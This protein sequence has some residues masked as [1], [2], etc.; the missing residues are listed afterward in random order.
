M[1]NSI[2][3]STLMAALC[4][5]AI[6]FS[7]FGHFQNGLFYY[8]FT[9]KISLETVTGQYVLRYINADKAKEKI[10]LLEK[11]GAFKNKE[12]KDDRT[13]IINALKD[14]DGAALQQL[15]NE[16]DIISAQPL[17]QTAKEKLA[18]SATEEILVRFKKDID[19]SNI[20]AILKK[21]N[22]TIL[23]KGE[24]FYTV[25]VPRK[26][27]TLQ[28]A[29]AIME[30]G[31]AEFSHPNFYRDIIMHQVPNDEYFGQQWNLHNVGQLINDGHTGTAD[32]DID[33]PEAWARTKG[34]N[35]I[36]I[37]V[38]DE[39][40]TSNHFDLPNTRQVRL[41]GSNFSTATPGN[42]PSPVG[43]GNHGN[44][45]AG[46]VAAT[47]DNSQGVA[48]VA[49]LCK[50]MPIKIL[51][52]SASDANIANAITFAKN[53][54][55]Q[56]LSNSWGYGTSL[57][58]FVPAI[59][60]AIT[61]ATTTGR[62]GL[63]CV[64]VFAA[65]NT[66]NHA[67]GNN[68]F[69]TFPGNVNVAGVLT[70]GASDRYDAQ[71]NYSPTS[72]T[73]STDNQVVDIVAPSHRAYPSQIRGED[74]EIWSMDIPGATGYNPNTT[75]T[76]LPAAG[77]NFD[78]YTGRMGGTSAACPQ[79]AGAAALLLSLNA[80][81]TQQQVFNIL[82]ENAD[83]VGGYTYNASGFSNEMGYGRLNLYR[84]V[85]KSGPDLYMKDQVTDAGLEP[86]PD[87][88]SAYF[89]SPDIW[90]RNT[91]DGG[92]THQ[93][94][95]YGQTN[96]VYV[97]VRNRGV[98]ASLATG[99]RLKLYWAKASASLGWTFPWTG[100]SYGCAG[101]P[102]NI[103]GAIG[104]KVI[105]AVS[106]GGTTTLV[107]SWT[108]PKPTDYAPCFGSDAS[109]FCLLARIETTPA[110]PYGMAFPE[111]TNLGDNVKKNN[112]IVWKNISI[113]NA[114]P[115]ATLIRTS[116]LVA[117]GK[118]LGRDFST[119][120]L[121]FKMPEEKENNNILEVADVEIDLG[122][123]AKDWLGRSGKVEGGF[124]T[125]DKQGK[126][127]VRLTSPKGTIYGIPVNPDQLASVTLTV[128]PR[129][130]NPG[131]LFLFDI[132]QMDKNTIIG[133]ERFDIQF[134]EKK[135]A[136]ATATSAV[137]TNPL[138]KT[139]QSGSQ[140]VIQLPDDKQYAVTIS[141]NFGQLFTAAKMINR[142]SVPVA[143][144]P[145]GVY[146]IKLINT[147]ENIAYTSSVMIQ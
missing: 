43:N 79:V 94:P 29:N 134:T 96:Y 67:S 65:G 71:A 26:A 115:D 95:E 76:Y 121:A 55:A 102:L 68:G 101:T 4:L 97:K 135:A 13:V 137:K 124:I 12:W 78:A 136:K 74:F 25:A 147:K 120:D 1:K 32:A 91:N 52:P 99:S 64:V 48:G 60:T 92:T 77:T 130:F 89:V 131:K 138:L 129:S 85:W 140:L 133:G 7:S 87:N 24:L 143:T 54:G 62:G 108:P 146:F 116:V 127:V 112:N 118:L 58:N 37:A 119:F 51:N 16:S 117:G 139:Y 6:V 45:C 126:T 27:N 81:L 61:D 30:S 70:V 69:V 90:V 57:S 42:D 31:V 128:M 142:L 46:L 9:E 88:A 56:I 5:A 72:N 10:A 22:V 36:T 40:V 28:V 141:N 19:S 3:L 82:T 110:V 84:A 35:T 105:P 100:A 73:A 33:A 103:G 113:V 75:G 144:Y 86:N 145:K 132:Q 66:A 50:I 15:Q 125:E 122:D 63:G 93:N 41:S 34:K 98:A 38:L 2:L 39:G 17:L 21:F 107:F 47:R 106:S 83:K 104:T 53:N 109:H 114:L 111:T 80:N 23:Q 59:V 44:A 123:L 14:K 49:P 18:L 8:A 11:S 20:E